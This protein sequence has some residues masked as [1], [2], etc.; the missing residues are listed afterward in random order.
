MVL[1]FNTFHVYLLSAIMLSGL[2]ACAKR[3][4]SSGSQRDPNNQDAEQQQVENDMG[5]KDAR[6]DTAK[7]A[8]LA[9]SLPK[10][11]LADP[12]KR[13]T[14]EDLAILRTLYRKTPKQVIDAIGHPISVE[15]LPDGKVR[16]TYHW[17]AV[18]YVIYQDDLVIDAYH[19]VGF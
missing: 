4:P 19:I 6:N 9:T 13:P 5:K 18:A 11:K 14:S 1:S 17:I 7:D 3:E 2:I 10:T 16:W 8:P 15:V 12:P